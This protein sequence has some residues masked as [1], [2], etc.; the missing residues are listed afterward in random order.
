MDSYGASVVLKRTIRP[1]LTPYGVDATISSISHYP[2]DK[3]ETSCMCRNAIQKSKH[4]YYGYSK[5]NHL[6]GLPGGKVDPGETPLEAAIRETFEE[7]G[8]SLVIND[9]IQEHPIY[10]GIEGNFEVYTFIAKLPENQ[11]FQQKEHNVKTVSIPVSSM[12]DCKITEF[13][14]YN[15]QLF[16]K[17]KETTIPNSNEQIE[18]NPTEFFSWYEKNSNEMQI[19]TLTI[20]ARQKELIKSELEIG[21]VI[22][23][24]I[25]NENGIGPVIYMISK[26]METG[27]VLKVNITEFQNW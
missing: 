8:I 16:L 5:N 22:H 24:E 15:R 26:D 20:S 10:V 9:T 18:I 1:L 7:T 11:S 19:G 4:D 12:Y 25:N 17:I 3:D 6:L 2:K 23:L 21:S 14:E 27:V 13:P